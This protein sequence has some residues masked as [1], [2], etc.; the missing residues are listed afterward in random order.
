MGTSENF[1]RAGIVF[2]FGGW[3]GAVGDCRYV[4]CAA[5]RAANL[6]ELV[7]KER[8]GVLPG[9]VTETGLLL[10]AEEIAGAYAQTGRFPGIAVVDDVM[11]YGRSMNLFL[12]QLWGTV[13]QCLDRLGVDVGGAEPA[14][15]GSVSL[16]VYAVSDGPLLLR[17]E[18]QWNMRCRRALPAD[19]CRS[20]ARSIAGL[21]AEGDVASTSYVISAKLPDGPDRYRPDPASWVPVEGPQYRGDRQE[22]EFY[23]FR[24]AAGPGPYPCVRS[25]RKQGHVYYTPYF[26]LP[27]LAWASAVRVLKALFAFSA[28]EDPETADECVRLLNRAK[29]CPSRLSAYAQFTV[30]LLSQVALGAFFGRLPPELA[31]TVEYDTG[32]IGRNFGVPGEMGPVLERFCRIGWD[33]ARLTA[34]LGRLGLPDGADGVRSLPE[35]RADAAGPLER[36]VYEQAVDHERDAAARARYDPAGVPAGLHVDGKGEQELWL[37]LSRAGEEAGAGSPLPALARLARMAD[38]GDVVLTMRSKRRDGAPVFYPSVRTTAASLAIMPGRLSGYYRQFRLLARLYWRD[39]DFPERV[40][41]YFRDVVFAGDPDGRN[42]AV[43]GDARYFAR[44]VAGNRP[45]VDAMLDWE[46]G[47]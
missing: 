16:W 17:P 32:K 27:E 41:R 15:N 2:D 31:G 46:P 12:S 6:L 11:V 24:R 21:V 43:I 37:L 8:P 25:C 5:R 40:E 9:Y 36:L 42:A 10:R 22:C 4:V 29:E 18:F 38:F 35:A 39:R 3:L 13:R 26:F 28:G 1:D 44:L 34:L 33:E 20:L 19:G 45:V 47:G 23:A 7:R 14:F 30:L